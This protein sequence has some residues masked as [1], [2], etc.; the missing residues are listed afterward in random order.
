MRYITVIAGLDRRIS[1]AQWTCAACTLP[2][3]PPLKRSTH[4]DYSP[5]NLRD[6]PPPTT[7]RNPS[8]STHTD[9]AALRASTKSSKISNTPLQTFLRSQDVAPSPKPFPAPGDTHGLFSSLHHGNLEDILAALSSALEDGDYLSG[10]PGTVWI[11]IVR[12]ADPLRSMPPFKR[13][14]GH[15]PASLMKNIGFD[16]DQEVELIVNF[17]LEMRRIR[18]A[19][20]VPFHFHEYRM[21]LQY[22]ARLGHPK[23][24]RQLFTSLKQSNMKPDVSCYN[25]LMDALVFDE[26]LKLR[27]MDPGKQLLRYG[28][29]ARFKGGRSDE[30]QIVYQHIKDDPTL[31]PDSNTHCTMMHALARDQDLTGACEILWNVWRLDASATTRD[32][33][34]LSDPSATPAFV[35]PVPRL[36]TTIAD[37]FGM[38]NQTS[39]A[40]RL[41]DYLNQKYGLRITRNV[42]H[43]LLYWT[44]LHTRAVSYRDR[45]QTGVK[46]IKELEKYSLLFDI[47]K[48]HAK[49]GSFNE[50]QD[51]HTRFKNSLGLRQIG[52]ESVTN[53]LEDGRKIY[54]QQRK[55]TQLLKMVQTRGLIPGRVA[56]AK[57][58]RLNNRTQT[59]TQRLQLA[60]MRRW[61]K[62]RLKRSVPDLY[63]PKDDGEGG[64]IASWYVRG[65]PNLVRKWRAYLPRSVKY[66]AGSGIV[67]LQLD[68][69]DDRARRIRRLRRGMRRGMKRPGNQTAQPIC[70][71]RRGR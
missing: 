19:I 61:V 62:L 9:R 21:L 64:R 27:F 14:H 24:A 45:K 36:L 28:K 68:K 31:Q 1:K 34:S 35:S 20:K 5:H 48:E 65:I 42:W 33:V 12:A 50:I 43:K 55:R 52:A 39:T 8:P 57:G 67:H 56:S 18:E 23:L 47:M 49:G 25:S 38:H 32:E 40:L 2:L 71:P 70:D 4:S 69:D 30:V 13:T 58:G 7:L 26:D 15:M 37:V 6:A 63:Q 10:L 17:I 3:F 51:L 66:Q 46:D 54:E 22:A 59:L 29:V 41:I 60:Y 53:S 16:Y 44:S 11:A